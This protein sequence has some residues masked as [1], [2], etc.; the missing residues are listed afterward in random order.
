MDMKQITCVFFGR[1][2]AG[3]GT[4]ATMLMEALKKADP[5]LKSIYVETGERLR[6]FMTGSS[7]SAAIVK[8]TLGQGK[9]LGAFIPIWVWTGFLIDEYTGSEHI[10]F[11]GVARRPEEAPILDSAMQLYS[12]QKPNVIFLDV[13]VPE[14]KSRLL[15]RGRHDDKDEKIAERLRAFETDIIHSVR[16]FEKSPNVNFISVNGHQAAEKVHAD[17]MKALEL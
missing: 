13:P 6:K 16:Y 7:Y 8:E 2:G 4:Q 12:K 15:K 10:I 11:D 3:K 17:I 14:V 5:S 9:L 1:A